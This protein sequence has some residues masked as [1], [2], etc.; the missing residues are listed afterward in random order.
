M[1][2]CIIGILVI[3]FFISVFVLIR[4]YQQ[5]W[6]G[7]VV[8]AGLALYS[9]WLFVEKFRINI[10]LIDGVWEI[11]SDLTARNF[12]FPF[13]LLMVS[14]FFSI[15]CLIASNMMKFKKLNK[16]EVFP[17]FINDKEADKL[18]N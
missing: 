1:A 7:M 11:Q 12:A 15:S 9:L 6:I 18:E 8:G 3:L 17:E 10:D 4:R 13:V 2:L 5:F 16:K 14:V